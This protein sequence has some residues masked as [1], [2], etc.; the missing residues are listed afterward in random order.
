M[1][2][3]SVDVIASRTPANGWRL[4]A[5]FELTSL[6]DVAP[7]LS[8]MRRLLDLDADPVAIDTALARDPALAALVARTPGVRVPGAVDP[9]ELVIRALVG[10]Q[11][12]V[13]AARTHL[14]RLAARAGATY[15]SS[16]PGLTRLFP[17][18]HQIVTTVPEPAIGEPLDPERP[19]RLPGQAIRG[20]LAI[21]RGLDDGTLTVDVGADAETLRAQLLAWPRIGSWTASYIA[22]RVLGD[23][24]AWL[25]GD[26]ALVAGAKAL[27]LL[28]DDATKA[29][30]HR[31]L[32]ARAA[33]WSPWRSYGIMHLWR[34]ATNSASVSEPP[35]QAQVSLPAANG[36][37]ADEG[38][39]TVGR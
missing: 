14:G 36:A 11:I 27:G 17:T 38:R 37:D 32:A 9:H 18:P 16:I 26:V 34:A 30:N 15:A 2:F 39:N 20:L 24:D 5:H 22:M 3:R 28:A 23:P 31:A 19:L 1:L 29:A 13:A 8:R 33:S 35:T 21:S 7:A 4:R 6:S 10:Q 12:S 25:D